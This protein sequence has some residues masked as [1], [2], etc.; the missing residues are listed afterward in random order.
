MWSHDG[1]A[2]LTQLK[3]PRAIKHTGEVW[4]HWFKILVSTW[5]LPPC[6]VT[7]EIL[8]LPNRTLSY[9]LRDPKATIGRSLSSL[10]ASSSA[11]W[12][13]WCPCPPAKGRGPSP[14][15]SWGR[16]IW[17]GPGRI[18]RPPHS[19]SRRT[20][21]G[22][23]RGAPIALTGLSGADTSTTIANVGYTEEIHL[24]SPKS[25]LEASCRGC[26]QE[27]TDTITAS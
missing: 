9:S 11:S 27:N 12:V 22:C 4:K 16:A 6:L 23:G 18:S 26:S 1:S 2:G 21:R 10:A 14:S 19:N 3:R 17:L 5:N 7:D 8:R 25:S 13:C 15:K 24:I 20:C